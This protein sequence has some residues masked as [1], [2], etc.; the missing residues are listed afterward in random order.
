MM[1]YVAELSLIAQFPGKLPPYTENGLTWKDPAVG[2]YDEMIAP[3]C[4]DTPTGL[5]GEA[6][7]W[8][9]GSNSLTIL[10]NE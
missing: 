5:L 7:L 6:C 1:E 8:A 2:Y 10:D 3:V 4:S 9:H